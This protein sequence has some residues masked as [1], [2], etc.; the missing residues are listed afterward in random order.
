MKLSPIKLQLE[1]R[2]RIGQ[3]LS[4][5]SQDWKPQFLG[6]QYIIMGSILGFLAT[7]QKKEVIL[8]FVIVRASIIIKGSTYTIIKGV[9]RKIHE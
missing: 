1:R 4:A 5:S 6:N 9:G 3:M 8:G 7:C 2:N